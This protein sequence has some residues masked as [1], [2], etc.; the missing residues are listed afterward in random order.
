MNYKIEGNNILFHVGYY[1]EEMLD[2]KKFTRKKFAKALG[3]STAEM[4][5]LINGD[6]NATDEQLKRLS[7]F[8]GLSYTYWYN[9]SLGL[10]A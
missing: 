7:N 8:T 4:N 10:K 5:K 3:L 2:N 9:V 1:I 6:I